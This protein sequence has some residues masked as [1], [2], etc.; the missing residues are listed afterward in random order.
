ML[1]RLSAKLMR[2]ALQYTDERAKIEG[3]L[4]SA[5]DVVKCA[6]WEVS[7]CIRPYF[8]WKVQFQGVIIAAVAGTSMS[9]CWRTQE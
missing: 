8:F 3:E 9:Y 4:L 2:A 7:A 1:V 5:M 6:T